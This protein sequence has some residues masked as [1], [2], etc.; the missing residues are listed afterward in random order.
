M[1]YIK[2]EESRLRGYYEHQAFA[3]TVHFEFDL[4]KNSNLDKA[5]RKRMNSI[6]LKGRSTA[7]VPAPIQGSNNADGS[8]MVE[9]DRDGPIPGPAIPSTG[10]E[11]R[12]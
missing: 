3:K 11:P 12:T 2:R 1:M 9:E 6:E 10:R 5:I 7:L 4:E 8:L